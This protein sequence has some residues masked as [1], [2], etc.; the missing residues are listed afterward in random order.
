MDQGRRYAVDMCWVDGSYADVGAVCGRPSRRA[1]RPLADRPG[2][3]LRPSPGPD[4]AQTA[5][6]TLTVNL[7]AIWDDPAERRGERELDARDDGALEP[8][9]TGFYAGESDLGMSADRP[10]ALLLA[11]EVEA[12]GEIRERLGPGRRKFGYLSED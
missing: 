1:A 8:L 4:V 2:L 10:G 3:G 11:G 12:T 9:M 5:N 7:Y 6:G